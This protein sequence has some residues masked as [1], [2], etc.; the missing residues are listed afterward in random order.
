M[1]VV[2]RAEDTKLDRPVALKFLPAHLLGDEDVRKR[3]ERE[4]KAAAALDHSNVCTVYEVDEADGKTFIAMSLVDGESLDKRIAQGPLKID[5]AIDI[6]QQIAKGLEAAH[7]RGI[8]HRDVKPENVMVD[9]K[10]HVTIMDFGLAQ[11]QQA[12][13]LTKADQTLGTT[14]YMSPEQTQGSG[15]DHRTDI[16]ALGAVIYEMV[17]GEQPFKGDYEKAVQYSIL[18]EPPEPITALRT[19]VPM[20]LELLVNKCLEKDSADR[21]GSAGELEKDLRALSRKL[22]SGVS[23]VRPATVATETAPRARR[24][25]P[26]PWLAFAVTGLALAGLAYVHF[27]EPDPVQIPHRRFS[28]TPPAPNEGRSISNHTISPDGKYIAYELEPEGIWVWPLDQTEPHP[29]AGAEAGQNPFWSPDSKSIGFFAAEELRTIAVEGGRATRICPS[30]NG[31][32]AWSPD[33]QTIV[34]ANWGSKDLFEVDAIGGEP[35]VLIEGERITTAFDMP[36]GSRVVPTEFLPDTSGGRA[37]LLYALASSGTVGVFDLDSGRILRLSDG[38]PARYSLSGHYLQSPGRT[39]SEIYATPFS[40]ETLEA[41]GSPFLVAEDGDGYPAVSVDG[42]LVYRN[43]ISLSLREFVWLDRKG[44]RAGSPWGT[45]KGLRY[46]ELSPSGEELLLIYDDGEADDVWVEDLARGVR[47][48]LTLNTAEEFSPFWS[49]D[50]TE[51]V[52]ASGGA[53]SEVMLQRADGDGDPRSI[54]ATDDAVYPSDWSPDGRH[55][56]Y[57]SLRRG[58]FDMRYLER[59]DD[60]SWVSVDLLS[61]PVSE[62]AGKFSPDGRYVAYM[63]GESGSSG[64]YIRRFP[65]GDRKVVVSSEG[66]AAPVWSRDGGELFFVRGKTLMAVPVRITGDR[67]TVGAAKALFDH[68]WLVTVA[69]PANYSVA[70]DGRFLV[71]D[72]REVSEEQEGPPG[73]RVVQ[74]WYEEF[75]DR[76]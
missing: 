24:A 46:A 10:G 72:R 71:I 58:R 6:A 41:T 54:L 70:A 7:E 74:N 9:D 4:A 33:G 64:V 12:S 23:R 48:R 17:V 55:I 30:Q 29:L 65:G 66:S 42:T 44:E 3:F 60:D 36:S 53:N 27:T 31:E 38:G 5:E 19:G 21:Y 16:W 52:Y 15:T 49:P 68:D 11:L 57:S 2:Y 62:G 67:L 13:R 59:R 14:A 39:V 56:L 40:L 34:F 61:T 32:G 35:R 37:L 1:G 63:S 8:V 76:E 18:N 47:T 75:R 25:S 51:V 50:G 73:F 22:E 43:L 69:G 26:L 45:S 28:L 20:E